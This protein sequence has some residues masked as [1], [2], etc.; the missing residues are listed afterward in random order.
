MLSC[1][2]AKGSQLSQSS[3]SDR[4][5]SMHDEIGGD[6]VNISVG[7]RI[8]PFSEIELEKGAD[9]KDPWNIVENEISPRSSR[10]QKFAFGTDIL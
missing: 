6:Q 4:N 2:H 8:R 3:K 10:I 1:G 7:V 9:E 5:R